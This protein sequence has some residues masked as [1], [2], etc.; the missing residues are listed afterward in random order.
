MM[1]CREVTVNDGR[2]LKQD[3]KSFE[4]LEVRSSGELWLFWE[5]QEGARKSAKDIKKSIWEARIDEQGLIQLQF[6]PDFLRSECQSSVGL[7]KKYTMDG[8]QLIYAEFDFD[9]GVC[10]NEVQGRTLKLDLRRVKGMAYA[11]VDIGPGREVLEG[12]E[13]DGKFAAYGGFLLK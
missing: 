5:S 10:A 3:Q 2:I 4:Y 12:T 1:A 13:V 7:L 6:K 11:W 9:P 8:D